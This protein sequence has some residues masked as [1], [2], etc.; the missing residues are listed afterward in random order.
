MLNM[1]K[2]QYT[3]NLQNSFGQQKTGG[4]RG[5]PFQTSHSN[6]FVHNNALG[7]LFP[8]HTLKHEIILVLGIYMVTKC[9]CSA[10]HHLNT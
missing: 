2:G 10:S 4:N 6:V 1:P 7:E 3:V 5:R 9:C 8:G